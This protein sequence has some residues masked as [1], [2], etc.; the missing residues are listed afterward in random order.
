MSEDSELEAQI[1]Q[2]RGYMRRRRAVAT[3]DTDELEDHLRSTITELT[4]L[5]LKPDEGFLVAVKRMGSQDELSREFAREHSGR[6]WKQLVL[7]PD[8]DSRSTAGDRTT[9]LTM[10][11]CGG[12]APGGHKRCGPVCG[13]G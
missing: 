10:V 4:G 9:L 12:G 6:L 7:T 13:G 1:A 3:T 8:S 5:G 11:G 2:W